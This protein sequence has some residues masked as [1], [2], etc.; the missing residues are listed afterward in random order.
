[1]EISATAQ[2]APKGRLPILRAR[3]AHLR[4][5]RD[6]IESQIQDAQER[7][8]ASA[9]AGAPDF[10]H[11]DAIQGQEQSMKTNSPVEMM[12]EIAAAEDQLRSL[13]K[14]AVQRA[15]ELRLGGASS[16]A[17]DPGGAE[18]RQQFD[19]LLCQIEQLEPG[20]SADILALVND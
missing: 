2:S 9:A 14:Q 10:R 3:L 6:G 5:V 8:D 18:V 15:G 1:V 16:Q 13:R 19:L 7:F 11:L 20:S 12:S 4:A 17:T